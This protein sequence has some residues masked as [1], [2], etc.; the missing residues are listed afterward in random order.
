LENRAASL[1]TSMGVLECA[2]GC[3]MSANNSARPSYFCNRPQGKPVDP[4]KPGDH[5]GRGYIIRTG[6][7]DYV[8]RRI[9]ALIGAAE[10]D[11]ESRE[12][13]ARVSEH[14]A[15]VN[16]T[17]EAAQERQAV[18]QERA[19]AT[20][21]LEQ[22]YDD[23]DLYRGDAVGRERWK[24]DI[25][26]QQTRIKA[27]DAGMETLGPHWHARAADRRVDGERRP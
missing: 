22:L 14:Y 21:A 19:D 6:L 5:E 27:A 2:C 15:E 18:I 17:P 11:D 23:A 20:R 4:T 26:T 25:S 8:A 10:W 1:L 24:R 9:F 13:L 12:I 7:D 16:E 3:S